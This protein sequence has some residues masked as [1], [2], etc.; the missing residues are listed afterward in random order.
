MITSLQGDDSRYCEITIYFPT[1][2]GLAFM[3]VYLN[4]LLVTS[5]DHKT[6]KKHLKT[7]FR[8]L[9]EYGIII[10]PD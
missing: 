6:R 3:F 5:P 8:R 9:T 7:I 10:G 1:A 2:R 4:D